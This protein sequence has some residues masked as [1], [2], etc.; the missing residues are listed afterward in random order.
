MKRTVK[1]PNGRCV[2]LGEYVRSW[3]ILKTLPPTREVTRFFDWPEPAAD[4]LRELRRGI[5]DRINRHLP[6]Y[7]A[8]RKWNPDWQRAMGHAARELN[9]PRLRIHYLPPDLKQRFAH[10]LAQV[11]E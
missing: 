1:L 11:G 4:I 8:G 10:R 5:H 6:G 3:R 9:D 7:G 2:T